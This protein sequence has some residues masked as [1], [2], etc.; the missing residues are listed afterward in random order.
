MHKMKKNGE[1]LKIFAEKFGLLK[2]MRTF[3]IPNGYNGGF[4]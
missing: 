3:A 1:N 4:V 2:I